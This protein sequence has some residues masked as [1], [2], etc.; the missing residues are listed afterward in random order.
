[1]VIG[2]SLAYASEQPQNP[3]AARLKIAYWP[4]ALVLFVTYPVVGEW[5]DNRD[6]GT[7]W[8]WKP[9]SVAAGIG[10]IFGVAHWLAASRKL[11]R[12]KVDG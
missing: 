12:A 9:F 2:L 3:T 11:H 1:V 5:W 8:F 7:S 4:L 6:W 10:L